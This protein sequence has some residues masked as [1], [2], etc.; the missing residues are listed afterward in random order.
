M[1]WLDDRKD[2]PAEIK[3]QQ[4]VSPGMSHSLCFMGLWISGERGQSEGPLQGCEAVRGDPVMVG[5]DRGLGG[6]VHA[7]QHGV[8]LADQSGNLPGRKCRG[9]GGM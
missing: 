6:E 7:D 4:A 8:A 3:Q 5:N 2:A 1:F 9:V